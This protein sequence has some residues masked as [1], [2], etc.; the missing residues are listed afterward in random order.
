MKAARWSAAVAGAIVVAS[1]AGFALVDALD[2]TPEPADELAAFSR[3]QVEQARARKEAY[4]REQ[5]AA[6]AYGD[7]EVAPLTGHDG[8]VIVEPPAGGVAID[9]P[10][11]PDDDPAPPLTI[12]IADDGGLFVGGDAVDEDELARRFRDLAIL[13]PEARI[14][15]AADRDVPYARVV[16]L[17]DAA[18]TA[19]LRRL[20]IATSPP[21][22]DTP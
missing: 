10:K 1:L 14:V 15:F 19:G 7:D 16:R 11:P 6:R 4:L 8:V 3:E 20:A 5:R 13:D 17:M 22:D 9:L 21:D 18:K 2:D 12:S